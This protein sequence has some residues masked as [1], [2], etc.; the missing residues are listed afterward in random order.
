MENDGLDDVFAGDVTPAVDEAATAAAAPEVESPP[1]EGSSD[2]AA[3]PEATADAAPPV[4]PGSA[5]ES[6]APA[7]AAEPEPPTT[8][9]IDWE[10]PELQAIRADAEQHRQLRAQLAEAQRLRQQ[11]EFQQ[12]VTDLADG[13]LERMQTI[14][15]LVAQATTPLMQHLQ[16]TETRA[17]SAEKALTALLISTRA[18]LPEE[19]V[20]TLLAEMEAL[21]GVEGPEL[22]ERVAFGKRDLAH[23]Y[24]TNLAAKDTRIQEL[25]RQISAQT[26][27]AQRGNADAVDSGTG[28]PAGSSDRKARM[29]AA[30]TDD[31]YFD[32]LWGSAA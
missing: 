12:R 15:G 20:S 5:P 10:H 8:P 11:Q 26:E 32:A 18:N 29:A 27:L 2:A 9:A 7:Q 19:Q 28:L 13:D 17:T 3:I 6:A 1:I 31:E 21:M 25:E 24:Q 23:H 4:V 30:K 22:M 16:G 14:N